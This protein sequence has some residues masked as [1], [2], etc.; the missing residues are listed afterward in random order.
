MKKIAL[1]CVLI[2]LVS[3]QVTPN[4]TFTV[5]GTIR[6]A[7]AKTVYLELNNADSRPVILD[8]AHLSADGKFSMQVDAGEE[9]LYSLRNENSPYPFALLIND[10]KKMSV[11]TD[12]A[13]QPFSYSVAGSDASQA[14]IDYDKAIGTRMNDVLSIR[15]AI[16]SLQKITAAG[17]ALASRDSAINVWV[18]RYDVASEEVK[19]Y[20]IDAMNKSKSPMFVLYALGSYQFRSRDVRENG[21]STTDVHQILS[22]ASSRFPGHVALNEQVKKAGSNKAPD[23]SLPDP[24]GRMISLSSFRGK[25]VLLDF[26]ASWCG[27]CRQENPNVVAAFNRFKDKNFTVLGVSLD[28]DKSAWTAAI[29]ADGLT[30]T[31]V[32]D[33]QFWNSAAAALYHVDGIPYNVLIDPQGNIIG[34]SLRGQDLTNALAKVLK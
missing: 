19:Q 31:H 13:A 30:W 25:Y 17:P 22:G 3:C 32:S 8:S 27:P 26:W 12:M 18:G 6:N 10:S 24:D 7:P 1:A 2:S 29:A 33:L 20:A 11:T 14:I 28:K 21:L 15:Q 23:F 16:D 4:K 9:A 34:E 5:D